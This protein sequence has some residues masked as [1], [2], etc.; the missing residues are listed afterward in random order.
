MKTV[1]SVLMALLLVLLP[2]SETAVSKQ[3]PEG[4]DSGNEAHPW[5]GDETPAGGD[6]GSDSYD[7]GSYRNATIGST[8]LLPLD[9]LLYKFLIKIYPQD[10]AKSG[11]VSGRTTTNNR[12]DISKTVQR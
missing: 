4:W 7:G 8:G 9:M 6:D 10:E 5:G 2:L 1:L 11:V 3:Y 12:S